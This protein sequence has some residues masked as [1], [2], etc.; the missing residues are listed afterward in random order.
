MAVSSETS[1][2]CS[3]RWLD[4]LVHTLRRLGVDVEAVL[5]TQGL[6]MEQLADSDLRVP[7]ARASGVW[8]AAYDAAGEPAFG[9]RVVDD[10][11]TEPFSLG[12]YLAAS[13]ETARQAYERGIRYARIAHGGL[14]FELRIDGGRSI[15][16][17]GFVGDDPISSETEYALGMMV[18]LAPF[19]A[20]GT[21]GEREVWFRHEVTDV[22]AREASAVFG[23]TVR[24]G[25]PCDAIVGN[26]KGLDHPLPRADSALCQLLEEHAAELLARV[27]RPLGFADRVRECLASELPCGCFGAEHVAATLGISPRTLRRRLQDAGLSYQQVL[28]EV[29]LGLARR[30]LGQEG[31]TVNEVAFLLGFSDASAFH[32]AFRRWTGS[33]PR[34]Y[35]FRHRNRGG[36]P[37]KG[38]TSR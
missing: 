16:R 37:P 19:V 9:I 33:G 28:D 1:P 23:C 22:Y 20:G 29:R 3:I 25:A 13:S 24:F 8:R 4:P 6:G 18:R 14:R 35:V 12:I 38:T 27:P 30:A 15:C 31:L 11:E 5:A 21:T 36:P 10:L 17:T 32:K 2:T 34:E 7:T 26:A